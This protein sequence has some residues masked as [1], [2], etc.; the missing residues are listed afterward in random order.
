MLFRSGI[1]KSYSELVY[2]CIHP[3]IVMVVEIRSNDF[4]SSGDGSNYRD[5][6]IKHGAIDPL[7]SLLSTPDL[8]GLSVSGHTH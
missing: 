2:I 3:D 8:S 6:V 4:L 5:Q 1:K 7:M